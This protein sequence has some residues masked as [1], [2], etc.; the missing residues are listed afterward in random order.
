MVTAVRFREV[1]IGIVQIPLA[2]RRT[3]VIAWRRRGIHAEL[4]HEPGANVVVV[5]IAADAKLLQLDFVGAKQF[6]RPAHRVVD[7]FV[8]VVGVGN[9][10]T[11][12]RGEELRIE[13]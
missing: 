11:D 10:G 12:F 4:R 5:K 7:W 13:S 2:L 9:I 3:G 6:A 8:E 1:A